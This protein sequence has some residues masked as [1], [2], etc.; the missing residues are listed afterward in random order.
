LKELRREGRKKIVGDVLWSYATNPVVPQHE[1]TLADLNKL[2]LSILTEIAV[3]EASILRLS[4]K[5]LW[6]GERYA[7]VMRCEEIDPGIYKSGLLFN[8]KN[9]DLVHTFP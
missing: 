5:G 3:R 8:P 2:G 4:A 7:T 9:A 6:E 1:G